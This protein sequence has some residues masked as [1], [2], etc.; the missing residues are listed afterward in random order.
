MERHA[1]V[2][3][4]FQVVHAVPEFIVVLMGR[5][6]I[7]IVFGIFLDG[8]MVEVGVPARQALVEVL[9]GGNL[10]EERLVVYSDMT[11]CHTG[12]VSRLRLRRTKG[13]RTLGMEHDV[14]KFPHLWCQLGMGPLL[15]AVRLGR[16]A[17]HANGVTT[18]EERHRLRAVAVSA[19]STEGGAGRVIRWLPPTRQV[20]LDFNFFRPSRRK[21]VYPLH[22]Y[23][24]K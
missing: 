21:I 6:G 22:L 23:H 9:A 20:A 7:V 14:L 11:G 16:Q 1:L 13:G 3:H 2:G 12:K 18:M 15:E 4:P 17:V 10:H 8:Q 24:F 19:V 5:C